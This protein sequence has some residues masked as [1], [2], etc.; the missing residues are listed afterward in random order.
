VQLEPSTDR[1]YS[2]A[3]AVADLV[4]DERRSRS[5]GSTLGVEPWGRERG[6]RGRDNARA[7]RRAR[8]EA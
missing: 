2:L 8:K 4:A 7:N 5:G 6:E 3:D 1:Y